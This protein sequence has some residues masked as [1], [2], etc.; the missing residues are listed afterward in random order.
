M[1]VQAHPGA[2][3]ERVALL[4][5]DTLGVWVRQRAVEG[6][7]NAAIE[8]ALAKALGVRTRQVEIVGGLTSRRKI[9]EV[10]LPDVDVLRARLVAYALRSDRS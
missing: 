1:T 2:R 8:A 5:E 10:D 7:A 3:V 6:Q 9:V 4:G